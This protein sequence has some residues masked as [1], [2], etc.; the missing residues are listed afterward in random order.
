MAQCKAQTRNGSRCT[1]PV[2][3]PSRSLCAGH[4]ESVARGSTVRNAETDRKF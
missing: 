4:Q 3:P 2:R 1:R